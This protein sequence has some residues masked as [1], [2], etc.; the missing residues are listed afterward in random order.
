M[1]NR[2]QVLFQVR[3]VV[4]CILAFSCVIIQ[5]SFLAFSVKEGDLKI[6]KTPFLID[7]YRRFKKKKV[8]DYGFNNY[9]EIDAKFKIIEYTN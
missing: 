8:E 6:K 7:L 5:H 1:L 4:V 2:C 3:I 9:E